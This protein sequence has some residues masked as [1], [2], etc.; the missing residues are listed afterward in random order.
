L[1]ADQ[2][3]RTKAMKKMS[4]AMICATSLL[5]LGG[6]GTLRGFVQQTSPKGNHA[7]PKTSQTGDVQRGKYL[8]EDVAKCAEC[9]TPRDE[10]G[11]LDSERWLQGAP[12]WITP[13]H[14]TANWA[15]HAPALAGF[16][17]YSD[18]DAAN[19][20]ER[21]IGTNGKTIQPPMHIYHM[22][23]EDAAAVVA[24]LRSLPARPE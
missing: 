7:A 11:Q 10:Q 13:V 14:P 16:A 12:V 21:G 3:P 19:I 23:H 22:S 24:Y 8:V 20:L 17:A 9:H 5:L 15:E 6:M 18:E 2:V 1:F 4:N